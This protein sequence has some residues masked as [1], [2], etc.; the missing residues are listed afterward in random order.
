MGL[1]QLQGY[2]TG[3]ILS[4]IV[5]VGGIL[6]LT[7]FTTTNPN[8]ASDGKI[9]NFNQTMNK[10]T[11][12]TTAVN[13]MSGSIENASTTNTGILGWLNALVG[14][15]FDGL[16]ALFISFS[17]VSVAAEESSTIFGIPPIFMALLVLILTIIIIF[18]IWSAITKV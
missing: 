7:T 9:N 16:K 6:F 14:S 11:E 15:I 18:A 12:V 3:I 1:D 13:E 4:I 17:F 5:I 8:L 2:I 10:A